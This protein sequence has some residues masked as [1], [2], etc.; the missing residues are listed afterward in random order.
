MD[1]EYLDG[2]FVAANT[3]MQL[4]FIQEQLKILLAALNFAAYPEIIGLVGMIYY[5]ESCNNTR[6]LLSVAST[7]PP[8]HMQE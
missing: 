3:Y 2:R 6:L 4:L 1:S 7:T 5:N 8:S